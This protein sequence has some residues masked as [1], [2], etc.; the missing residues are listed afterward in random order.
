MKSLVKKTAGHCFDILLSHV[1]KNIIKVESSNII[2]E[3]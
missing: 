1:E 3:S 2:A